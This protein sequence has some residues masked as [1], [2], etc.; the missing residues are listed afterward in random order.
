[1]LSSF[2]SRK[3]LLEITLH[4]LHGTSAALHHFKKEICKLK[5]NIAIAWENAVI[6]QKKIGAS[7][8]QEPAE[9]A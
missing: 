9:V 7:Q 6:K 4:V 3:Q 8:G 5:W 1:M 2:Q